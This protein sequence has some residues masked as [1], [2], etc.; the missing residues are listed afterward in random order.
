MGVFASSSLT[1][2][3]AQMVTDQDLVQALLAHAML[4]DATASAQKRATDSDVRRTF[5]LFGDPA[6][7][8][9]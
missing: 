2:P 3:H 5:L 8:L 1:D 7:R 9:R 4:G 6:M